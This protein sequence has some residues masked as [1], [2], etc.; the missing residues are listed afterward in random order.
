MNSATRKSR[1]GIGSRISSLFMTAALL[2]TSFTGLGSTLASTPVEAASNS[3]GLMNTVQEGVILHAW[4]WSFNN[5]KANMQ[6]IAESGYTAVQTSVIQQAKEATAGKTNEVWWVY[7][8]PANFT[9]DNT[10]GSALGNKADFTAMCAEAHKYGIHVI[11][12]VVANHL[13]NQTKYDLSNSIPDDIRNDSSC[14]HPE[15]FVEINYQDRYSIT[16]SSMGGLP[17]LNTESSKIQNYVVNY[18]K[19]CIDCGA[20]GFRFDAAKHIS[21]PEEGTQYTFWS[22]VIPAARDYYSTKGTYGELY[23]YGEILD[24]TQGPSV[25]AYTQYMSVTDNKTGNEIRGS[26]ADGNAAGAAASNYKLGAAPNKTV[27]WAESHDTYSNDSKES[28]YVSDSNI[29]KTWAMVA[30]RNQATALYFARTNGWRNGKIGE[31]LSTQCFNKEVVEVNKFHNYFN[32]QGEYLSSSS[33]IAYNERGT[34]GVVLINVSGGSTSVSVAA[35]KIADGSYKDQVSGNTFTVSGGTISGNIGDTGIAVVYNPGPMGGV[36]ATPGDTPFDDSITV[37]LNAT[38]VTNPQYTTTEGASG[39]YT[40]GQKITIGASSDVGTTITLT[41]T[42]TKSDGSTSTATYKYTKRDPNASTKIY[43][44]NSSY[45]WS[46]PTAYVYNGDGETAQSM[47][48]WPGTAMTKGS[49]YYELDVT[50]YENGRVIFSDAGSATNRYPANMQPGLSIGGTSMLFSSGNSWKPYSPPTPSLKVSLAAS[51]SSVE[52]GTAVTLTATATGSTGTVNYT[53]KTG[54]TTIQAASANNKATWTPTEAGSYTITVTAADSSGSATATTTVT[55]TKPDVPTPTVTS[56]KAS[57]TSF[58]TE[59]LDI[60]LS[61]SN[62]TGGTYSVD[63]GPTKTFTGTQTVTIG[64]GKIGDSTVTVETTA[65]DGSTTKTYTFTYEKQYVK[66][67]TA[68]SAA[69]SCTYYATN[70]GGNVGAKKTIT[71]ASDFTAETLVAQGIANDDPG[72]FR[73]THEAPKFDLYALYAAWDDTNLYIGIQYTNVT[74]IIDPAQESPQTGR[75]K[76][77]GA[78]ANIPQMILLDTKTGDYTDGS[79]NSTTQSTVWNTQVTF[80]GDTKVDR[81]IMYS[82]KEG[83]DNWAIFPVTGGVIDYNKKIGFG[84]QQP[85]PGASLAWEDGFF[86]STMMGINDNGNAGYKPADIESTSSRW[87]DF[88]T[89]NHSKTQD[90]FCIMTMPLEYLG[91]TANDI[92]TNGIGIMAVATYG[93]SGMG[94]LPHDTCMV[95][96]AKEPYVSDDSTS[97]EKCDADQITVPLASVGKSGGVVPVPPPTPSLPLQVNFGTD[98]SAPQL[99]TTALTLKGIGYGGTAPYSY[100]FSV[101]GTVV[102]AK[103]ST[104]TYSWKPGTA[105]SHTIKCVITDSTG[106]TATVSKTFTAESTNP[107]ELVNSSKISATTIAKNGSVTVTGAASGGSGSYTYAVLYRKSGASSWTTKQDFSST[108][109]TSITFSTAGQYE[110]CSKVKDSSGTVAEKTFNVTVQDDDPTTLVNNSTLASS[111]VTLGSKVTVKGAASGGSGSYT[112]AAYYKLTSASSYTTARDFGSTANISFTPSKEGKYDVCSKVKDSS[113]TIAKKYFTVTV[114]ASELVNNT[115][116]A[117]DSIT[118]GSKATVKNAASGGSGSYT[119][120]V[121]YKKS[122]DSSWVTA[123]DGTSATSATFTPGKAAT[124]NVCSKVKDSKGDTA[125]KYLTLK[126]TEALTNKSTVSATS[127]ELGK[128]VTVKCAASGGSGYYNYAVLYKKSSDSSWVTAQDYKS[129]SSV[130]ITPKKATTYNICVKVKDSAGTVAKKTINVKVVAALTNNAKLAATSIN[131]G[132]SAT[133]KNAATGG[134]GSYTYYVYYKKT[135]D[136]DWVTAQDGTTATS[137]TFKPGKATTYDVCSKVKD[138]AGTIAKKYLTLKVTAALTNNA[139]LAATSITLG[140]KA[141]VKNAAT[142]GSGSYTYYVYYKKTSDSDW[143]TAQ[144]GTTATSASFKPGKATTYD[145]CS[146]VKDSKGTIAKKYLTLKVT[147]ASALT[148]NTTLAATS[149]VLGNKVTVKNA[150][151]GGSGTYTYGVYYKLSSASDW[152]TVQ[153]ATKASGVAFQP[154]K[155]GTYSVCSKVK[156]SAGTVVK[157]YLTVKVTSASLTN[158]TTVSDTSVTL[159]N[160]VTVFNAATGG[161]GTYSFASYYKLTTDSSWTT[162]QSL[163]TVAGA[164]FTPTKTGSYDVCSK[165]QDSAGTLVKK[166]F[167]VKVTKAA[168]TNKSTISAT[169]VNK[170]TKVTIKNAASGSSSYKYANYYM[171]ENDTGWTTLQSYT[172]TTSVSFTPAAAGSYQ[173]CSKVKDGSDNI[174]RKYFIVTVK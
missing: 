111:S 30:S 76:P 75:G 47:S 112:Y 82:P 36:S 96:N 113:G 155:A 56:S 14:W 10:G 65:T 11:V 129:T 86:G 145:V 67:T 19:E 135:S 94:C 27:L 131:L 58:T 55:V 119:Y 172:T 149:V 137:V 5:I 45:N 154:T 173:V 50:G 8:Q 114:T 92:A 6:K 33:S 153:T 116:L 108:K 42:G 144:D 43:F 89:T 162:V 103:S 140:N 2:A 95:D 156:D 91:I 12:D 32:G 9:I 161:S 61:L 73:G 164:S 3:Y 166:Y 90:T 167:V 40:D 122:S 13:G 139:S 163:S 109:S 168:L 84:Y 141:T 52:T 35:H 170:G 102:K 132:N 23:C 15:G 18:L 80:G 110:V 46:T 7:Y 117:A 31:I 98:K 71:S 105:G 130:T 142:G 128:T 151:A 53:F 16:H 81:V 4:E 107:N 118:L 54:S 126:V 120:Y 49:T 63:G 22:T 68:S 138:S 121:Y 83:I 148:N 85:L 1:W 60:T 171:S 123:Q 21:V 158:A 115:T 136:S 150:A 100:E 93:E 160:S 101:D 79:T 37:T 66:K 41:L 57:G 146:K 51:A 134:S 127:I 26:V 143:V 147:S 159:G 88:L 77:N 59:T 87:V 104:D 125:K 39:S 25:G 99:T 124:Y 24:G 48:A 97:G 106:A 29:N 169:S 70:P 17:D 78:D 20:D 44:D 64:E 72:A 152:T 38:D 34:S 62:A 74:D 28:T 133:V 157:K 174:V 69:S 165:V